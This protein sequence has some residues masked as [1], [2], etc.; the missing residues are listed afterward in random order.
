MKK[1]TEGYYRHRETYDGVKI[2]LTAKSEKDLTEKVRQRK[3][4][5]DSGNTLS[6]KN[7]IV[8]TWCEEWLKTYKEPYIT[9]K[10][11]GTYLYI[12]N[13]Q[14]NPEIGAMRLK[15]VKP[16]HL[17]RIITGRIGKSASHIMRVKTTLGGVF[18]QAKLNG[19]IL[20]DP[21]ENLTLPNTESKFHRCITDDEKKIL[22]K[23][24]ETHPHG[25]Y[26]L[27]MY[28]C[29]LRPQE[30][31]ALRWKDIDLKSILLHITKAIENGTKNVK[32]TKSRSGLRDIPIPDELITRLTSAR[33][34]DETLVLPNDSGEQADN[35]ACHRWWK[36][37]RRAMSIEMGAKVYR[38]ELLSDLVAKDFTAY[39]LR[40][41]YC[42]NLQRAGVPLNVAKYLMGHSDVKMTAN[43]YG[44]QTED[45]TE[46]ARILIN[47]FNDKNKPQT[48][49][50]AVT[51]RYKVR[52][53]L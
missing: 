34:A 27:L 41:T 46:S 37:L 18:R 7:I 49:T 16:V 15:D 10:G 32:S 14:I 39:C 2:D 31:I 24:C 20:T 36:A 11:Y 12:V 33:G 43:I 42:T 17:Q 53:M 5:I 40:H 13:N 45:Q 9:K 30:A 8:K 19:Y 1:N 6:S 50:N 52:K 28:H 29:G 47:G 48:G 4:E 44:H 26:A 51:K 23:V 38:N 21:S 3:N 22:L 25:L 35:N